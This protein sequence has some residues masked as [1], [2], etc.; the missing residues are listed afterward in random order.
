MKPILVLGATGYVGGR[1]V[2]RLLE[3]GY[4]VR[5][6]SRS[7]KKLQ[8]R[9]WANHP[10]IELVAADVMNHASF[11]SAAQGC[12]VVYYLVHS[13]NPSHRDF[14]KA[15]RIAAG[16]MSEVADEASI[17]R[18][19]YLSGL[20]ENDGALSK[21]LRSRAEVATILQR[22]KTPV[23]ILRAAMIIG[24]GSAS[25]EILRYL[26]D[27]LPIMIT[28]KWVS[29][30]CQPIAIRNVLGYLI[31][32]LN[33]PETA[34]RT[35][36]IGGPDILNYR[37]LMNLYAEESGLGRRWIVPI[38]FFT[39]RI[40]SYWIHLITPVPAFIAMPL[41]EGLRNPVICQENDIRR[42]IPQT[43]LSC[44]EAVRHALTLIQEQQIETH[45]TD[46]GQ[47][48]PVEM[49]YP[50]DPD[51]SGGTVYSD[52]RRILVQ[53]NAETLWKSVIRIGGK[54]GWYY[55]D[56]LWRLRGFLDRLLGGVGDRRGRRNASSVRPGDALDFWR[57]LTVDPASKLRLFA[58]MKLPGMALLDFE[59]QPDGS[60]NTCLIQTAWFVPKG[61]GGILYWFA[62]MPLHNFIFKGMLEGI[63]VKNGMRLLPLSDEV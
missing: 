36:D 33:H 56:W 11:L 4:R 43:L 24:S 47:L 38:P 52:Q 60:G 6:V 30:V 49:V 9:P 7:I 26:V 59:L 14:A 12:S 21:H 48:P 42:M 40:S 5:A 34:S 35:L 44:R 41:A 25:F 2:P 55:G 28:P 63:A 45:W 54:T 16:I 22:G 15:D 51:W 46:A 39:P 1:L 18:I 13:M 50:G 19:I 32:C 37:E 20:G 61:L 29:V 27:R 62:V 3:A 57:V 10:N 53:A 58:E 23:T 31:G 17:E 8:G